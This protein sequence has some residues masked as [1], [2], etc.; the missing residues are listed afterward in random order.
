M[1]VVATL[2]LALSPTATTAAAS[3]ERPAA[4]EFMREFVLS[5]LAPGVA[6]PAPSTG[7]Y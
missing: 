7:P 4:E 5:S 2:V 6:L 1:L 3:Q